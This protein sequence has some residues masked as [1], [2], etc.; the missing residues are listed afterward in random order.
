[1]SEYNNIMKVKTQIFKCTGL[2][3]SDL[4]NP[5]YRV[6]PHFDIIITDIVSIFAG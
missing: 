6:L 3:P 2:M 5:L 4:G 1:M